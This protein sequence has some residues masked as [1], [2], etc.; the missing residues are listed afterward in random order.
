MLLQ[1]FL[2][3]VEGLPH[4]NR[5][6]LAVCNDLAVKFVSL[7]RILEEIVERLRHICVRDL[8]APSEEALS[9]KMCFRKERMQNDFKC[10]LHSLSRAAL[11]ASRR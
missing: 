7:G 5:R 1:G 3:V 10:A 6:T 9:L 11:R 4:L 2:K 8:F